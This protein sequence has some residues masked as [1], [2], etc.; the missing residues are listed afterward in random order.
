MANFK[1][2]LITLMLVLSLSFTGCMVTMP[3][4]GNDSNAMIG[5]DSSNSNNVAD[6]DNTDGDSSLNTPSLGDDEDD[7]TGGN[8]ANGDDLGGESS[9]TPVV[10]D[11][12]STDT[13]D[14]VEDTT[15]NAGD[16]ES[17]DD[18]DIST[19]I[20][21]VTCVSGTQKAYT[22]DSDT[23]TLTFGAINEDT[24]Y[25]IKGELNGNIVID[26]VNDYKFDL[27]LCGVTLSSSTT[28]PIYINSGNKVSITA[29]NGYENRIYDARAT[30]DPNDTTVYSAAIYSMVDLEIC[31]KGSLTVVSDNNNGI[32][33]KDD[34]EVK[35][36]TLKV[37]CVDNALKGNDSVTIESGN[38]TLIS[39]AGDGIK[40]D[41][42]DIS[43]K[44]NQ[45]GYINILGGTTNIYC[46]CDGIDASY[47][48]VISGT[49]T[50]VNIYTDRYSEY[51]DEVTATTSGKYYIKYNSN[52]YNFSVKYTN[53]S[54]GESVF[55]NATYYTSTSS[56][57]GGWRPG[58][59]SSKSYY[60]TVEVP[61]GYDKLTVY[62][63]NSSQTQG[64]DSNYY[65]CTES[66][67]LNTSNDTISLSGT[68][69]LTLS[70]TNYTTSSTQPGGMGGMQEGNSDKGDYSTK[71]IKSANAISISG[72]KIL[73][74]AYDD[75]I[76]ANKTDSTGTATLLGNG[77]YAT[78]N[79]TLSGGTISMLSHD[80]GVHADGTLL[81][82]GAIVNVSSS[83]EG[84][85][86]TNVEIAGGY[87]SIKSTDDGINGATSVVISGGNLYMYTTGDGLD[88]NG[89]LS[90]SGGYSVV[91]A[92][93]NGN[94]ALDSDK[95]YTYTGGKLVAIMPSGGMTSE[96]TNCSNFS[97]IG[98]KATLS[99]TAS[100]YL[101]VK[102]NSS[103]VLAVQNPASISA[104]VV[105]LGSNSATIQSA[106]SVSNTLDGN[107]VYWAN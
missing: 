6:S 48:A 77:S 71:G 24:V 39:T 4:S 60:Y 50:V 35:N 69:T 49:D 18:V 30:V 85:E 20:D 34:L 38:L 36:L 46:A 54:T 37:T 87:V 42:S 97:S 53:S 80:D 44:G 70:W 11:A 83:Y 15:E 13:G 79:V 66:K 5:G 78:G 45:R 29:K 62:M 26:V 52:A 27:E 32:R 12:P 9:Q 104:M 33:T 61:S 56:S 19:D 58:S 21:F 25:S 59:S 55:K 81:V 84:L 28:N 100:Q 51:S 14:K 94:A 103:V 68:T 8:A 105:Y 99:L 91:I 74:K 90:I 10:P 93:S 88:S 22:Y 41:N 67:S 1:K 107:G 92:N 3:P 23:G 96:M 106:S 82:N 31:G 57:Q 73:I 7:T 63:Y 47:D 64:Q 72:G 75:A 40:T 17:S 43:E 102:V 86:G 98:T 95:G 65:A 89:T 2:I 76:H 101:T 16:L